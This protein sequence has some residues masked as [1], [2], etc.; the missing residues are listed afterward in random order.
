M[1]YAFWYLSIRKVRFGCMPMSLSPSFSLCH[2]S[3]LCPKP[4]SLL[5][6]IICSGLLS[7][8]GSFSARAGAPVPSPAM[9]YLESECMFAVYAHLCLHR[10]FLPIFTF[11]SLLVCVCL[12]KQL[13]FLFLPFPILLSASCLSVFASLHLVKSISASS[14]SGPWGLGLRFLPRLRARGVGSL[15]DELTVSWLQILGD[16]SSALLQLPR[17]L[18]EKESSTVPARVRGREEP[19]APAS[20]QILGPA[21]IYSCQV[22]P[23]A[24]KLGY[25][26]LNGG[27]TNYFLWPSV[28][29]IISGLILPFLVP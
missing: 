11:V 4:A 28:S 19:I 20:T 3:D 7:V 9:V 5:A 27:W 23:Q 17:D 6:S 21:H 16:S 24:H 18:A 14:C 22:F 26:L 15:R 29:L 8:L 10:L 1:P 12:E 13:F 25:R 2:Y